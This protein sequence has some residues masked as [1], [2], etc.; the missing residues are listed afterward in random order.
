MY[1]LKRIKTAPVVSKERPEI[2]LM[3]SHGPILT[4][5]RGWFTR[6]SGEFFQTS[7]I[8][9]VAFPHENIVKFWTKSGSVYEVKQI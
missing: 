4:G 7:E 5:V 1:E 2:E 6:E 8:I 9:D 3:V